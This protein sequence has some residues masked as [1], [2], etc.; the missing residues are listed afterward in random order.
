MTAPSS[1]GA[2][3]VDDCIDAFDEDFGNIQLSQI[4]LT[5]RP[6]DQARHRRELVLA[7]SFSRTRSASTQ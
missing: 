7:R 2:P 3:T 1:T 6:D 5:D 4:R